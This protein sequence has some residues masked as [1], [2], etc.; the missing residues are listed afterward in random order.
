MIQPP[1][2]FIFNGSFNKKISF[3]GGVL[4]IIIAIKVIQQD[5]VMFATC[6][7]LLVFYQ[8]IEHKLQ[9]VMEKMTSSSSF[10]FETPYFLLP[11]GLVMFSLSIAS[12]VIMQYHTVKYS[13]LYLAFLSSLV[14][15]LSIFTLATSIKCFLI[16]AKIITYRYIRRGFFGVFERF[17][18]LYR[19]VICTYRWLCFFSNIWPAPT[20]VAFLSANKTTACY[21]YIVMKCVLLIWLLWDFVFSI[22]S[23]RVNSVNAICPAPADMHCDYCVICQEVPIEPVILPCGHIF[24]YQCAYRWLLTNSSCPMCRKPVKEQV[25]IEF[26]DGHIPLSALLSVF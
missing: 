1:Q 12:F 11:W 22:R 6:T 8:I 2:G 25:A 23:Y 9:D 13:N 4:C 21:I 16:G 10:Y 14:N 17:F 7:T 20:V 15:T 3:M 26:S 5:L 24:C 19:S 18:V